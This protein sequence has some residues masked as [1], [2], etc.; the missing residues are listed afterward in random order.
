MKMEVYLFL[1]EIHEMHTSN[2]KINPR[3]FSTLKLLT[4]SENFSTVILH[5]VTIETV[6]PNS[7]HQVLAASKYLE[8][9]RPVPIRFTL[10]RY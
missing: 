6:G 1:M 7:D 5:R 9:L 10:V 3:Q 2:S 8:V 4:C